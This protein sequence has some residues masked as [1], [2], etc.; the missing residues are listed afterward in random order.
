MAS[1]LFCS[2]PAASWSRS[3]ACPRSWSSARWRCYAADSARM[4]SY[5]EVVREGF[6]PPTKGL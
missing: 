1:E 2:T 5:F 4:P 6:E 3:R